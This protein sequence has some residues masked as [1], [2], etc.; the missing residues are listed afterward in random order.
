MRWDFLLDEELNIHLVEANMSPDLMQEGVRQIRTKNEHLIFSAMNTMGYNLGGGHKHGIRDSDIFLDIH[1]C[2]TDTCQDCSK[3]QCRLCSKCLSE[4]DTKMLKV[5][6]A[7]NINRQGLRRV[8]PPQMTQKD[9]RS[10]DET[11]DRQLS[12]SDQINMAWF[13]QKCI[14]DSAWCT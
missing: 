6:F 9:A 1:I 10:Y 8:Y 12:V 7:E 11:K 2:H 3:Q 13:R 4:D 5:S 14:E